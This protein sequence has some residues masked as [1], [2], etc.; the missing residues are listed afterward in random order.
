MHILVSSDSTTQSFALK[1]IAGILYYRQIFGLEKF[2]SLVDPVS[3]Q[4]G[5]TNNEARGRLLVAM[6]IQRQDTEGL[7]SF[8]ETH[9]VAENAVQLVAIQEI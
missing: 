2:V 7:Q 5:W 9:V 4:S 8:T 6:V 1:R 3:G